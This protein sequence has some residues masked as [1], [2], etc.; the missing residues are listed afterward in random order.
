MEEKEFGGATIRCKIEEIEDN[1]D[2]HP[3]WQRVGRGYDQEKNQRGGR[4][5]VKLCIV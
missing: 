1:I 4:G 5:K 2:V 3:V